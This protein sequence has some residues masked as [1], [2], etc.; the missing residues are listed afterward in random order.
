MRDLMLEVGVGRGP[1]GMRDLSRGG[2]G[3]TG[4]VSI[5]TMRGEMSEEIIREGKGRE[6]D[7]ELLFPCWN[8]NVLTVVFF[9][10]STSNPYASAT[11]AQLQGLLVSSLLRAWRRH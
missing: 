3:G 7:D 1:G 10:Y 5:G 4:R 11:R 8:G 6:E 9:N 2:I